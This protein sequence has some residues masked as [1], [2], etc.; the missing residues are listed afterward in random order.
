MPAGSILDVGCGGGEFLAT[1][2]GAYCKHGV[3]PAESAAAGARRRGVTLLGRNLDEARASGQLFDVITL[4][5]VI[6]HLPAPLEQL[7]VA[8]EL[9]RP[10]GL[11]IITTA[12]TDVLPWRLMRTT[13]W[14][15]Y[16]QH[17]TF[18]NPKWFRFAARRL[19]MQCVA[20]ERFCYYGGV[21]PAV[22]EKLRGLRAPRPCSPQGERPTEPL[23]TRLW[24]DHMIVAL[25]RRLR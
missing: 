5:N 2:P 10:G 24:P 8:A 11:L 25:G 12:N 18:Y 13:Y 17:V 3:E 1:L 22:L 6:E 4:M 9:L 23:S 16:P 21:L 19:G 20:V 7:E 15:Y 14:Y